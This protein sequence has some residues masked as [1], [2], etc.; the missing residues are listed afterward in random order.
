MLAIL[1]NV[2]NDTYLLTL[3]ILSWDFILQ[4]HLHTGE[5]INIRIFTAALFTLVNN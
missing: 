2:T 3:Q 1:S 4:I 5:I